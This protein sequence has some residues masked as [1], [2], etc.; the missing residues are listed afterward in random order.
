MRN[1]GKL[2]SQ[3]QLLQ[4]VW[5]PQYDDETNYLRVHMAHIR[6]KLEPE[7]ARP[8]YFVTEPGWAT[9]SSARTPARRPFRI[10]RISVPPAS[11]Q[12]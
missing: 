11:G 1:P 5:G 3:R 12:R 6:R 2:V 9:A 4:E 8:R 10:V 7:P